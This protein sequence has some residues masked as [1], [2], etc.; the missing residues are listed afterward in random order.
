MSRSEQKILQYIAEA[1]ASELALVRVLQSQIM[2][3]PRGEYRRALER[4]LT[5]TREHARRLER[6]TAELGGAENLVQA[7]VG[8]LEGVAGQLLAFAKTPLDLIRGSGGE[9]KVLKD[10]K[11]AAA[12][13]ALEIATYRALE[14]LAQAAGDTET[15]RLAASIRRE[16]ERMLERILRM[17]PA[18]TDDVAKAELEGRGSYDIGRTGAADATRTAQKRARSAAS[19]AQAKGRSTARKAR[20]VPGVAR[21]EGRAKGAVA[22]EGDLA[23]PRFDQLTAEEV[24]QRLPELS[25]IELA[26]VEAYERRNQ[27]RSTVTGRI[28]ALQ[29]Q[30]PWPGYDELSAGE[31]RAVLG[32]R[33]EAVAREVVTYERSHKNRSSVLEVAEREREHV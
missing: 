17:V 9:E 6:R 2:I 10:A 11:D 5:E 13:E 3:A 7:A 1:H 19:R 27:D 8:L 18:L 22:S 31:I 28:Q 24:V 16:E 29:A 26:K 21:A 32:E 12:T 4:H 25:Q 30:E 23:I 33:D 14:R 15:A 20:K